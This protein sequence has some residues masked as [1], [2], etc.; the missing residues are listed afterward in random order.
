MIGLGCSATVLSREGLSPLESLWAVSKIA[1]KLTDVNRLIRNS[2]PKARRRWVARVAKYVSEYEL[3]S[4]GLS[5]VANVPSLFCTELISESWCATNE[6]WLAIEKVLFFYPQ[7]IASSLL[8]KLSEV[9]AGVLSGCPGSALA[10]LAGLRE[11]SAAALAQ[12]GVR[13]LV[14]RQGHIL[15]PNVFEG[16]TFTSPLNSSTHVASTRFGDSSLLQTSG[17]MMTTMTM[18]ATR[19]PAALPTPPSATTAGGRRGRGR[20]NRHLGALTITNEIVTDR[21]IDHIAGAEMATFS[22]ALVYLCRFGAIRALLFVYHRN[23]QRR[24]GHDSLCTLPWCTASV[25]RCSH[26]SAIALKIHSSTPAMHPHWLT[27]SSPG[28]KC[29]PAP[30][31]SRCCPWPTCGYL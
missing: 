15:S 11:V 6:F 27:V 16:M 17:D 8:R 20:G 3:T 2:E 14:E 18:T 28:G 12:P 9:K 21:I 29:H 7:D 4:W 24:G 26:Y 22:D 19:S 10:V 1:G 23:S 25:R 5:L 30:W 31:N 13:R